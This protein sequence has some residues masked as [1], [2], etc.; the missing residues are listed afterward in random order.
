MLKFSLK[1][2]SPLQKCLGALLPLAVVIEVLQSQSAEDP[3]MAKLR[4]SNIMVDGG[5]FCDHGGERLPVFIMAE[6]MTRSSLCFPFAVTL[7]AL[8]SAAAKIIDNALL[9]RASVFRYHFTLFN[10]SDPC[11]ETTCYPDG[12]P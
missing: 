3:A 9:A 11:D 12:F 4:S 10:T 1:M 2:R 6:R 7:F 5:A 8:I